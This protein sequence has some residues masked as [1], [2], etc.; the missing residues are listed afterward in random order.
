MDQRTLDQIEKIAENSAYMRGQWDA[1]IPTVLASNEDHETRLSSVENKLSNM[2]GRL[3]V[4]A[5][6]GGGLMWLVGYWI[7]KT[8]N[9]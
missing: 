8:L 7:K 4:T 3:T 6:A 5:A 2:Q 9:L 1:T